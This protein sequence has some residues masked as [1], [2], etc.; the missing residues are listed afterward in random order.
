MDFIEFLEKDFLGQVNKDTSI[1]IRRDS[2]DSNNLG[3]LSGV[4]LDS[5]D[6]SGYIYYWSKGFL[7]YALYNVRDDKEEIP[8]TI[9][10][11]DNYQ[12]LAVIKAILTY[13][14]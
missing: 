14:K 1:T 2:S 8:T 13:F 4:D 10:E 11:T 3:V 6:F 7:D 12:Q 9:I 5:P